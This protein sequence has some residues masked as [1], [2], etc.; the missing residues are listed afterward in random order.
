MDSSLIIEEEAKHF[1]HTLSLTHTQNH[2]TGKSSKQH[3]PRTSENSQHLCTTET[4]MF[5]LALLLHVLL[6]CQGREQAK[7]IARVGFAIRNSIAQQLEQ[8][9]IPVIDWIIAMRLPLQRNVYAT[10]ISVYAP[11][12]TNLKRLR[13]SCTTV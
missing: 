1:S 7:R 13:W 3:C 2:L 12:M 4:D 8:D 5:A 6:E 9:P 10:I 11:T